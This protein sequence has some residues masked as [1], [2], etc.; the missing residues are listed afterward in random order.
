MFASVIPLAAN[1]LKGTWLGTSS[2]D[3]LA[4][5]Q[6][7]LGPFWGHSFDMG[8]SASESGLSEGTINVLVVFSA[9]SA[10]LFASCNLNFLK[11]VFFFML[12]FLK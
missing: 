8:A 2:G 3:G 4:S 5:T 6:A 12:I 10:F 11:F 1:R 9:V 7:S